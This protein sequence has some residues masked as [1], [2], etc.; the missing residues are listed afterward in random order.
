MMLNKAQVMNRVKNFKTIGIVGGVDFIQGAEL[1]MEMVRY[2][3]NILGFTKDQQFPEIINI[4]LPLLGNREAY[5]LNSIKML[6]EAMV[7]IIVLPSFFTD[8]YCNEIKKKCNVN[9]PI[10]A[11]NELTKLTK[12][13]FDFIEQTQTTRRVAYTINPLS[14]INERKIHHYLIRDQKNLFSVGV[15]GGG[16]VEASSEY[17]LELAKKGIAHIHY[18]VSTAPDKNNA[19]LRIGESFIPHY[20][21]ATKLLEAMGAHV[22]TTPCNTAHAFIKEFALNQPIIDIREAL[23]SNA[24]SQYD[25]QHFIILATDGT[26][27]QKLYEN[28]IINGKNTI[29]FEGNAPIE[30]KKGSIYLY[31]PLP[32]DQKQIMK[33][34]YDIKKGF[35]RKSDVTQTLPQDII[36][37]VVNAIRIRIQDTQCPVLLACTELHLPF[38]QGAMIENNYISSSHALKDIVLQTSYQYL[39]PSITI[40]SLDVKFDDAK[41]DK[42]LSISS[43]SNA[44][45][46]IINKYGIRVFE[47]KG[48]VLEK[49]T[50][51]INVLRL[52][53]INPDEFS[54]KEMKLALTKLANLFSLF[55][56]NIIRKHYESSW[57]I[58]IQDDDNARNLLSENN[59]SIDKSIVFSKEI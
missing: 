39:E 33:A 36:M 38:S 44:I 53:I 43:S 24:I 34:I 45:A 17:C 52:K 19:I 56:N 50:S 47:G 51:E 1:V 8:K 15:I 59:I 25:T 4:S 58:T 29:V 32:D 28:L 14:E 16:G 26:F 11:G 27:K 37:Q 23:L 20:Q 31:R 40:D 7:D 3:T 46:K 41:A 21:N 9:I 54:K 30:E 18:C 12:N 57:S 35:H 42:D 2:G 48:R 6:D 55:R 22:L 49:F 13:I 10:I 5:L